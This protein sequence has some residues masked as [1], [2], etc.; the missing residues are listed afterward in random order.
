[1][2]RPKMLIIKADA[3]VEP[4]VKTERKQRVIVSTGLWDAL[5]N[6]LLETN[7]FYKETYK[8]KQSNSHW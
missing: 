4:I 8:K 1:M 3:L 2:F 5:N 7:V 6:A